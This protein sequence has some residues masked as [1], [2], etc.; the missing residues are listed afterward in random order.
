MDLP[1]TSSVLYPRLFAHVFGEN[2][3]FSVKYYDALMKNGILK[4]DNERF[5]REEQVWLEAQGIWGDD[6]VR[7]NMTL[8]EFKDLVSKNINRFD[9][10]GNVGE[11]LAS[12]D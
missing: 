7:Q 8:G 5:D 11:W 1:I 2:N 12:V 9:D 10:G 6:K 4:K 3:G